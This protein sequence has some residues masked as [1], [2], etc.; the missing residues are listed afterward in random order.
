MKK[1]AWF[2]AIACMMFILPGCANETAM[3]EHEEGVQENSSAYHKIDAREAKSMMDKEKV[4]I[5][6]VRTEQEYKEKHIPNSILVPNATIDEEAKDKLPDKNAVLL[7]HCRTGIRSKQASDKLVQM[8]YKHVYDFGGIN[9][10]P[11]D[12]VSE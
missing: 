3:N 7:V 12:T 8:G 9:D 5:V 1:I 10:W 2:M 6:D 11:Y 4:T